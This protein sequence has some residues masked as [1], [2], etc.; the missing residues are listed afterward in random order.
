MLRHWL[1]LISV[2][3]CIHTKGEHIQ[4]LV[5]Y[6]IVTSLLRS[7]KVSNLYQTGV[8]FPLIGKANKLCYL[9]GDLK[10]IEIRKGKS[11]FS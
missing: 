11:L 4:C 5:Y 6:F 3:N 2:S 1:Y 8:N 10:H 7:L 9:P